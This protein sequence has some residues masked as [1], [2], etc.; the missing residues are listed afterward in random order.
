VIKLKGM[1]SALTT[2]TFEIVVEPDEDRWHAYC[3]ALVERGLA[4]WA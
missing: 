4:T 3:P 1:E 2:Y